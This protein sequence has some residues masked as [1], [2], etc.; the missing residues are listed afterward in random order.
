MV[1]RKIILTVIYLHG[2]GYKLLLIAITLLLIAVSCQQYDWGMIIPPFS[3][4]GEIGSE[5]NPY[6]ISSQEDLESLRS[7]NTEG[8]YF[9]LSADI[10]LNDSFD[11]I[12]V[13]KGTLIGNGHTV[14]GLETKE[15][16]SF[17][18]YVA[19]GGYVMDETR[20]FSAFIQ[21][22]D[23]GKISDIKFEN[24]NIKAPPASTNN[25]H[26]YMAVAVGAVSN[27]ATVEKIVIGSGTL[28]SPVRAGGVAAYV[29][30]TD[31]SNTVNTI[32]ECINNA[33]ITTEIMTDTYG[34]AGGV[35]STT[36][37]GP[38]LIEACENTGTITGYVAGG[39]IGDIQNNLG[40]GRTSD[41]TTINGILLNNC[42]NSG[43]ICGVEYAGG[44][45]GNF[46]YGAG[47]INSASNSGKIECYIPD[48]VTAPAK[49]KLGGIIGASLVS[50]NKRTTHYII[51]SRNTGDIANEE[52]S[53]T[54][55]IGGII[56]TATLGHIT[57]ENCYMERGT[58]KTVEG[59]DQAYSST[60]DPVEEVSVG[61]IIGK[62]EGNQ[63]TIR[64]SYAFDDVIYNIPAG[65]RYGEIAGYFGSAT[66]DVSPG[67]KFDDGTTADW[68]DEADIERM[69]NQVLFDEPTEIKQPFGVFT[70]LQYSRA[71]RAENITAE[72]FYIGGASRYVTDEITQSWVT[73]KTIYDLTGCKIKELH[74]DLDFGSRG[75]GGRQTSVLKGV[76]IEELIIDVDTGE[77][78][79]YA[80]IGI[81]FEIDDSFSFTNNATVH[82]YLNINNTQYKSASGNIT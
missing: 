78:P 19:A 25:N 46:W 28:T 41:G 56:G 26:R 47:D 40:T 70:A 39:I 57:I 49:T 68:T 77:E 30:N 12:P 38:V 79:D 75:G 14:S 54:A 45:A 17:D 74:R 18:E 10:I 27:G 11:P 35:V 42:S 71:L 69:M 29:K 8:I 52:N 55:Y 33:D 22:L 3:R 2:G 64:N 24:F 9:E 53:V 58:L 6:T 1:Q 80:P 51:N 5:S 61:G 72:K 62:T 48:G 13:F 34:T 66:F 31:G 32:A 7:M 23:G 36:A 43:N 76:D 59:P 63:I 4:P 67:Y 82:F 16:A 37:D 21:V 20:T 50:D 60:K 73:G 15:Y 65:Y 81:Y 44:I